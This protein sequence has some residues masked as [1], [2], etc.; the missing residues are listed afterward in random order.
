[1]V[2]DFASGLD[3]GPVIEWYHSHRS[4]GPTLIE[5][6]QLR[7]DLQPPY[8]HECIVVFTRSGH[9][10]RVDRRPDA[11]A[12]FDTIMKAGCKT[13]DMIQT[14]GSRSLTELQKTSDCVVELH[15]PGER[16][17]DLL[18]ILSVCFALSQDQQARQYTLQRYNCYFLSWTIVMIAMRDT[19]AWETR[20]NTVITEVFSR[21]EWKEN[22]HV[23]GAVSQVL[24]RALDWERELERLLDW[25]RKLERERGRTNVFGLVNPQAARARALALAREL[26]YDSEVGSDSEVG[27][28]S[29]VGYDS[30]VGHDS[31]LDQGPVLQA[32]EYILRQA[33]KAVRQVVGDDLM[34]ELNAPGGEDNAGQGFNLNVMLQPLTDK[35]QELMRQGL[36][37]MSKLLFPGDLD[38]WQSRMLK[39]V[40]SRRVTRSST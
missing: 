34:L 10:Y 11:D 24:E 36:D 23:T 18:L 2:L 1:M 7:K 4:K 14:V 35:L 26:G 16:T 25:Q 6:L 9:R 31:G 29:E 17:I 39:T 37:P 28:N 21:D 22:L 33:M 30:E 13:Y 32:E 3:K 12:P 40:Q 20:L 5:K 27:Y 8:Y 15:W 38:I 19:A